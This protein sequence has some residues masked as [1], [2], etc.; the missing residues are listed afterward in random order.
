MVQSIDHDK[1]V[2]SVVYESPPGVLLVPFHL[3]KFVPST[4]LLKTDVLLSQPEGFPENAKQGTPCMD[5]GTG[6]EKSSVTPC[7]E[8]PP[9]QHKDN[10]PSQEGD[11]NICDQPTAA[12]EGEDQYKDDQLSQEGDHNMC[13]QSKQETA[14]A[15]AKGVAVPGPSGAVAEKAKD[16]AVP[17]SSAAALSGTGPSAAAEKAKDVAL[18]GSSAVAS[19]GPGPSGALAEKAGHLGLQFVLH[20]QCSVR[21]DNKAVTTHSA[22]S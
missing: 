1:G 9:N 8:M 2:V 16:V 21:R 10:Q 19:S 14:K 6:S 20:K 11:R 5:V 7:A 15:Q 3:C 13:G 17:G 12:A 18:P 4:V 22:D